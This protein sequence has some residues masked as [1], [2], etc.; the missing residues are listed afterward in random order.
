[1]SKMRSAPARLND[2][3]AQF[4]RDVRRLLVDVVHA[5]LERLRT[6]PLVLPGTR[7]VVSRAAP[8]SLTAPSPIYDKRARPTATARA[9][10][11]STTAAATGAA[12]IPAATTAGTP[13]VAVPVEP[14]AAPVA[15]PAPVAITPASAP[16]AVGM[17]AANEPTIM[18]A[19]T[20]ALTAHG[21]G[22]TGTE[23]ER[24]PTESHRDRAARRREERAARRQERQARARRRRAAAH[25]RDAA[26][27]TSSVVEVP[28]PPAAAAPA[29]PA[30]R[31]PETLGTSGAAVVVRRRVSAA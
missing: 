25:T 12:I 17:D 6:V 28:A 11:R 3:I 27:E 18:R 29:S 26:I 14:V 24:E 13:A 2:A 10:T 16:A 15:A 31:E 4:D 20:P 30:A 7:P 19:A 21:V 23:Q 1:M 22:S 5:E 8:A 9:A